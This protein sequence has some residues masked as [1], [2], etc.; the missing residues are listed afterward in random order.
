[1][2]RL[3]W[4]GAPIPIPY[5]ATRRSLSWDGKAIRGKNGFVCMVE[6]SWMAAFDSPEFW[7]PKVRRAECLNRQAARSMLPIADL[8][9]RMV[10]AGHSTRT[11]L[12]SLPDN[13]SRKQNQRENDRRV[14]HHLGD[15]PKLV[16][17][18]PG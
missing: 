1:M 13:P 4:R 6:R 11:P 15:L 8:R 12:S 5:P 7:N 9:T 18:H 17:D 10:L 16:A 2:L 3:C 14:L